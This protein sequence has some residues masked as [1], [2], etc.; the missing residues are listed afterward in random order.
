MRRE[1]RIRRDVI[2]FCIAFVS[3]RYYGKITLYVK[4]LYAYN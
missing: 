2:H 4:I 1:S 3:G